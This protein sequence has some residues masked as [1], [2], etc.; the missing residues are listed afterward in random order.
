EITNTG[1]VAV[2]VGGYSFDDDDA[3]AG[4]SGG[5]PAYLLQPGASMIVLDNDT[6]TTFR[7]LWDI[8]PA[9]RIIA[10]SELSNFP[11]LGAGGDEIYLFNN[12]NGLVD[13]FVFGSA[14]EGFSFARFNNGQAVPGGLSSKGV[15]GAYESDDPDEDVGSPG[16]STNLPD[17][18]PPFFVAP[19]KTAGVAGSSLSVSE[20]RVRS[21]DPNPGDTNTHALSGAPAWLTLT[22][23]SN[24]VSRFAGTPTAGDIGSHTFAVIATDN[25]SLSSSRS[26]RIDVLPTSSP[27]ILNEYNAVEPVEFLN[28]G[29][30]DDLDGRSDPIFGRIEGNGG[31]W[32]EF[33]VTQAID[34]RSWTLKIVSDDVTRILK[35]SDHVALSAIPAGTILT[36]TESKKVTPTSFNQI[37]NLNTNGFA[38]SN[39]WMHDPLLID[40]ENSIHPSIPAIGSDDTRFIWTNAFDQIIYGPS[41]ESI[42]LA[43]TN[44]NGIGDSQV[45]VGGVETFRLEANPIPTTTP[46]NINYD[47]GGTSSFGAPNQWS[48]DTITQGFT[49]YISANTPPQ[50]GLISTDKAVRGGFVAQADFSAGATISSLALPDFIELSTTGT[51]L[52]LSNNRALTIADIGTYEVTLQADNG[53]ASNNLS[54]LVFEL[55][56]LHPAPSVVLNEYNAVEPDRYL[57]GGTGAADEDGA[58]ASGDSQFGRILGNGGNWF[59]LAVV[60]DDTPGTVNLTNWTIEV[61][62]IVPSGKFVKA[63]T[64]VLSDASSWSAIAH[65]TLLTFIERNSVA[66]GLDTEFNRT[67]NRATEGYAWSNIHLGTP[68]FITGTNLNDIRINSSNTAFVIKDATGLVIFGPAGEGIAPVDGV[69]SSEIFELENDASS[70]V[71]P[72]DDAS[73]TVLGY[74]DGSSGST[75]GS[76]NLFSPLGS[77]T[78]RA[79]DFTPYIFTASAFEIYLAGLGLEGAQ[80]GDDSDQDGFSNL[81]EYLLGGNPAIASLTPVTLLDDVTGTISMNVRI[82]DPAYSF[83]AERSS[84][85]ETWVTTE[86]EVSDDV[87]ELGPDFILRQIT[88]GGTAPRM[89]FRV[90]TGSQN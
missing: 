5:F 70:S 71:S 25:T 55:E 77:P 26:Y 28:G 20:F 90:S 17:P 16:I 24:G 60:G 52:T 11:G 68:G 46:L 75:F 88:Y 41:G 40:Q 14:T 62:Q 81:D 50:I 29:N 51:T 58:P 80:A 83:I 12:S 57:N 84:D 49:P 13:S 79:Q 82:N 35:L 27:I 53:A 1:A 3:T 47:D 21:V 73:D 59:E 76:P 67:D 85:L 74:D 4:A 61:G 23:V 33:V 37:S 9:I 87:S 36:F 31:A 69:G 45:A 6:S 42:A 72:V 43:D 39:I 10:G 64:I 30:E 34:L 54:Y 78:D 32:A 38:W 2:N 44:F 48:N 65:G 19:F 15:F 22:S 56:V 63:T 7:P 86:L 66:G 18:L 8:D 89:F